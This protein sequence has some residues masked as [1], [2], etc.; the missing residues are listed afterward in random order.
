MKIAGRAKWL[1]KLERMPK[2]IKKEA[3]VAL[4]TGADEM[5]ELAKSF[6]PVRTGKLRDSITWRYGEAEKIA[7][8][9]GLGA[10]HELAVVISAGNKGARHAHLVEFGTTPHTNKG[11][12]KGASHPG[13][14][15][16]PYFY[17]SYRLLKRRMKSRVTRSINKAIKKVVA[18]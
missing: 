12:F 16:S 5:V 14:A 18:T 15:A 13:T 17:P 11:K 7:Y 9:Q 4:A 1:A 3:R 6:V 8:S 10:N 2:E